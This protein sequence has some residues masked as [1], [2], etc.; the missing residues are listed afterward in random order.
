MNHAWPETDR[1]YRA[2]LG[3]TRGLD[4]SEQVS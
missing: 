1:N 4:A 2:G 3:L